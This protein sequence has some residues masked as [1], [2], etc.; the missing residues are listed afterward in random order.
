MSDL[1]DSGD[2]FLDISTS[3][4]GLELSGPVVASSGPL[5]RTADDAARLEQAGAAAV[6]LPSL[7]EEDVID[8]EMDMVD[9]MDTGEAFAEFASAPMDLTSVPET[10]AVRHLRLVENVRD[11]V[12]IPVIASLNATDH[13]SWQRYATQLQE[14][15]ADAL[16]LNLY[17]VAANPHQ[18]AADI[19]ARQLDI[20][21]SV[22]Q[23][24]DIP[25]AVKL[26]PYYTS[27]AA[28]AAGVVEAGADG[29]VI[30]N[31]FYAPD[32]DLDL[33]RVEPRL[34]LSRS[35]DLRIALRWAGILRAQLP[36]TSIA[37]TGGVHSGADVLKAL[38]V[39]ADVACTTAALIEGGPQVLTA[40]LEGMRDWLDENG[41]TSVEQLQGSMSATAVPNPGDFERSQY[42][43]L[44]TG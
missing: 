12:D 43:A 28:F 41:Y 26:S 9:L 25:L 29:L 42:R 36:H 32:I 2:D 21:S 27:F 18:S 44:I 35:E 7:F 24:V 3:Y 13:G 14:S 1:D 10:G 33:L 37:V 17:A 16:E 40:M 34:A 31:R 5:T 19:E 15:G 8:E 6:V 39:G 30:F 23:S 4:L 20:I 11:A 22:K 38:L